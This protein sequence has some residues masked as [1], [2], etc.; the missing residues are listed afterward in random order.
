MDVLQD[1]VVLRLRVNVREPGIDVFLYG[2]E[3]ARRHVRAQ[4]RVVVPRPE[5]GP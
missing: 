5:V 2:A 3:A 4:A 1:L